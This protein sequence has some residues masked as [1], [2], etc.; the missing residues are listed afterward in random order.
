ML[1]TL[2]PAH[3]SNGILIGFIETF[4]IFRMFDFIA[5]LL[6]KNV[7]FIIFFFSENPSTF[8]RVV[9]NEIFLQV[10]SDLTAFCSSSIDLF[11][12]LETVDSICDKS[13]QLAKGLLKVTFSNR[14]S[15]QCN[16]R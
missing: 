9:Q 5:K 6:L 10:P 14:S 1:A 12:F 8:E 2:L 4:A 16:E 3:F 11:T 7:A 13:Y 15:L